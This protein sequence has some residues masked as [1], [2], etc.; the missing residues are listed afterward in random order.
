MRGCAWGTGALCAFS[1]SRKA[2]REPDLIS[3]L[4]TYVQQI[5]LLIEAFFPQEEI[6]YA[7]RGI[8]LI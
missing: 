8:Q 1:R 3:E 4:D 7:P 5:I 2:V 6:R